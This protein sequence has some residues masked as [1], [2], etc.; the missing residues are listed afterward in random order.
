MA[1]DS[2]GSQNQ[3]QY[4]STG[5]P[6]DAADLSE[7][8]N[9]AA[10][11]G[12]RKTG[13]T[14]QRNTATGADVWEGLLWG[15]TTDKKEYKYTSG[16][17]VYA[18][19]VQWFGQVSV[20][21]NATNGVTQVVNFPAGLFTVAPLVFATLQFSPGTAQKLRASVNGTSA[22]S[23]TLV[24]SSGDGSATTTGGNVAI[25]AVQARTGSA[26]S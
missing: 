26:T 9:Y 16:G 10:L 7:L 5:V 19:P 21:L 15:D 11:V 24:V 3:P 1:R 13:T 4:S 20:T 6:A 2:S 12:N 25:H 14:S 23:T 8:G 17:W 22:S 18:A